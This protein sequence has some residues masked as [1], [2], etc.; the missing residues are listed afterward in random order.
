VFDL[1]RE[2]TELKFILK[3][4]YRSSRQPDKAIFNRVGSGLDS[5]AGQELVGA[6]ISAKNGEADVDIRIN[7]VFRTQEL[8]TKNARLV[9]NGVFLVLMGEI[10]NLGKETGYTTSF[11]ALAD[12][13]GRTFSDN[14]PNLPVIIDLLRTIDATKFSSAATVAPGLTRRFY[15]VYELSLE[16]GPFKLTTNEGFDNP[17]LPNTKS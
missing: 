5:K 8:K 6:I 14:P 16:V 4:E 9:A 2:A 1:P 10:T 13:H 3:S 11:T 7:E 15:Q 12:Q 17:R